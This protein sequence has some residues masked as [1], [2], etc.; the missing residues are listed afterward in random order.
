M[1]K[2]TNGGGVDMRTTMCVLY[3]V[4]MC[5][6]MRVLYLKVVTAIILF[7]FSYKTDIMAYKKATR[8]LF[9]IS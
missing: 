9:L 6:T 2:I 5:T 3:C 1:N 4:V 8:V 7:N